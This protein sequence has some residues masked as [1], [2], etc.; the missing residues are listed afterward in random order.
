MSDILDTSYEGRDIQINANLADVGDDINILSKEPGLRMVHAGVGWDENAFDTSAIDL[1]F[2]VFLLGKDEK[3]R[4]DEDFVFYNNPEV[5][6]GGVKHNGDSRT[7]AGDGD[8][9]SFSIDLQSV[10][11]DIFRIVFV[12]GIYRGEERD[13]HLGKIQNAYLRIANGTNM[14]EIVRFDFNKYID[15]TRHSAMIL[16]SLDR[17]GPKWHFRPK[18][19]G[20]EGNLAEVARRYGCIITQS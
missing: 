7:G 12:I 2:C 14:N 19:E 13:Q 11:F 20:V 4:V 6:N 15:D 17:E 18:N 9:E 1:D 3:T 16:G 5:F 8:D 10:P